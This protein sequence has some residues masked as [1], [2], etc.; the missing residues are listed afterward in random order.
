M[1]KCSIKKQPLSFLPVRPD[2]LAVKGGNCI[3]LL[4]T[5]SYIFVFLPFLCNLISMFYIFVHELDSFILFIHITWKRKKILSLFWQ[6][7]RIS[8][9][10]SMRFYKV[11]DIQF[12]H[13]V[14]CYE[15]WNIEPI[16]NGTF[17]LSKQQN[18][19]SALNL[20]TLKS[21]LYQKLELSFFLTYICKN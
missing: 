9:T 21:R 5:C 16:F 14:K 20:H 4:L 8:D 1:G 12:W 11:I 7:K 6:V 3:S 13:S 18:N 17:K 19:F 10:Y 2:L 15:L